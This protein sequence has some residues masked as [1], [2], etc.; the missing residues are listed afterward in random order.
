M[1]GI[2]GIFGFGGIEESA[3][4]T[5][6]RMASALRHR[7]PDDEGIWIDENVEIALVHRR[8]SII[9]LS[10]SGH[11]PMVSSD[12]RLVLIFNGEIYNHADIRAEMRVAY[13]GIQWRGHSDTETLIE[14]VARWGLEKTLTR[15]LGMY[16]FAIWDRGLRRLHL[17]RDRLGEKPLYYGRIGRSFVFASELKGM[18]VHPRWTGDINRGALALYMRHNYVP[19]PYCIYAGISKLPPA[20]VLTI[21]NAD[22]D[23][24][25]TPRRYWSPLAAASNGL[26]EPE[27]ADSSAIEKCLEQTLRDAVRGQLQADVPLG[28]FLSGGVD[29]STVVALM[30]SE[31]T[32][33]VRTFSIGFH[34][35]AYDEAQYARKVAAHLQTVHT[36]LYVTPSEAMAVVPRLPA[37]YDE[38]FADPSQV[39]TFLVSQLARTQ[40]TVSLSG[41]GGDELFGGYNRYFWTRDLWRVFK[42]IPAEARLAMAKGIESIPPGSWDY[43]YAHLTLSRT[44]RHKLFG[45]KLHKLAEVMPARTPEE[46]YALL[47]SHWR[48]PEDLVLGAQALCQISDPHVND[49]V[50]DATL[51]MMLLDTTTYLPDDILVKLDRASM[52]VSLESR[53]PFLDHR[54]VEYAWRIPLTLKVDRNVGKVILRKILYR[55]VPRELIERPKQGFALPIDRW[56]RGP[57][58]EWGESLLSEQ[59][60]RE[61]GYLDPALVRTRWAE[62]LSGRRNWQYLLWG[63]LMWQEWLEHQRSF[64]V[65]NEQIAAVA[66]ETAH[67][68]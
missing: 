46:M 22:Q 2:A 34:E 18:T 42:W 62:H 11:Q 14:A 61:G 9:D 39:P 54:L 56:L 25:S 4:R 10:S 28:A 57:L 19:S 64:A 5:A 38:P 49:I 12:E 67:A 59:R 1:C 30:Q 40:V 66:Q 21:S 44:K 68:P 41:D 24:R 33:P 48:H 51:R 35:D 47:V 50:R 29:S 63:V 6:Q 26:A 15:L 45:D 58:R 60:L 53:V 32:S 27:T 37:I 8:L 7:G 17:V 13:P 36:E 16:A 65:H 43:L 23:S 20:S 3:R 31:S 52:A 55:F